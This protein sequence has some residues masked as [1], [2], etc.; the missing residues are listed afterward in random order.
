MANLS[1]G[2]ISFALQNYTERRGWLRHAPGNNLL[3]GRVV[4]AFAT[5]GF[6]VSRVAGI[7]H[8]SLCLS[9]AFVYRFALPFWKPRDGP[10]KFNPI[11]ICETEAKPNRWLKPKV[12]TLSTRRESPNRCVRLRAH[13]LVEMIITL[14]ILNNNLENIC[15]HSSVDY[16]I[17]LC[18]TLHVH[19]HLTAYLHRQ[20]RNKKNLIKTA[21]IQWRIFWRNFGAYL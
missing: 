4:F 10:V 7:C 1:R 5:R 11:Q 8:L 16:A 18:S 15:S 12:Q 6:G 2:K 9:G 21:T 3:F 13:L 14:M 17:N 20:K 19:D